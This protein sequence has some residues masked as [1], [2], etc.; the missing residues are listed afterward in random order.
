LPDRLVYSPIGSGT[1]VKE[2]KTRQTDGFTDN[3]ITLRGFTVDSS[4]EC[5]FQPSKASYT[6]TVGDRS[7]TLDVEQESVTNSNFKV[8]RCD[9]AGLIC[10]GSNGFKQWTINIFLG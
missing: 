1:C 10:K 6:V 8:T 2:F 3:W 9:G 7:L 4:F 5:W